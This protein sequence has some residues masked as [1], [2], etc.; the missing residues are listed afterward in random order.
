MDKFDRIY[1]LHGLLAGR[2]T[3]VSL[4]DLRAHLG[5]CSR[6][7]VLRLIKDLRDRLG[8]PVEYDREGDGYRYP[9]ADRANTY[10]LPGLWFT[11]QELQ[12]LMVF[13]R[14]MET[15]GPGLL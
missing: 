11:A 14:L 3:P 13:R 9:P 1:A 7:T 8:A 6:A 10:E 2:R 4:E 12:A 15:L 5:D